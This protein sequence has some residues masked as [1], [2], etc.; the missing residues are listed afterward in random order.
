MDSGESPLSFLRLLLQ[1]GADIHHKSRLPDD[2]QSDSPNPEPGSEPSGS[3]CMTLVERICHCGNIPDCQ[4][5][6]MILTLHQAGYN[7]SVDSF[8]EDKNCKYTK[9]L[10]NSESY[11]NI[12]EKKRT[13]NALLAQCRR[14]IVDYIADPCWTRLNQLQSCGL[15]S[16]M[17]DYLHF[18]D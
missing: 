5:I 16:L 8:L 7:L 3:N 6:E 15:P 9:W 17:V 4:R 14:V 11:T 12:I 18:T 10:R 1:Y 2:V 13:A